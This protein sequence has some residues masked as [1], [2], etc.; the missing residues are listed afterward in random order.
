MRP[1]VTVRFRGADGVAAGVRL[2]EAIPP[3][4]ALVTVVNAKT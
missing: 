3:R 4:P 1:G 2:T